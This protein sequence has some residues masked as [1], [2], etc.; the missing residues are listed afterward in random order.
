MLIGEHYASLHGYIASLVYNTSDVDDVLQETCVT[1]WRKRE[2]FDRS[3]DF[4]RWACGFAYIEV[5]RCRQRTA[6]S[7]LWFDEE[8]THALA[9]ELNAQPL[10]ASLRSEALSRCL[11]VLPARDREI[12]EARYTHERSVPEIG[13]ALGRPASTIYK[14]LIRIRE[15]LAACIRASLAQEGHADV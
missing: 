7:R 15:Q 9:D 5:L 6:R 10:W 2:E 8:T 14:K 12:I 11:S 4:Y 13:D 1:L 3:K